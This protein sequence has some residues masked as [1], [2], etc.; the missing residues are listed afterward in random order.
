MYSSYK[1]HHTLKFLI[2]IAPSGYITFLSQVYGGRA[3]DCYITANSGILDL[4]QPGDE[5]EYLKV[6]A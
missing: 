3:T 2:G 1:S 5:V 4:L 6:G